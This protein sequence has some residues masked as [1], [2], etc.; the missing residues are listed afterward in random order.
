MNRDAAILQWL[1]RI[2]ALYFASVSLAHAMELKLPGL[3]IYFNVPS[4]PYQDH[5]I[6]FM[7]FGWAVFYFVASVNPRDNPLVVKGVI[8]SSAVAIAG[9]ARINIYDEL[10]LISPGVNLL[11]FWL[12]TTILA[13]Y[14]GWLV[15]FH[16]KSRR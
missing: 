4:F 5:I 16:V 11:H 10:E 12:Q 14:I 13:V 7:T 8:L 1:L 15:I 2:G 3:F 6:A 9:L